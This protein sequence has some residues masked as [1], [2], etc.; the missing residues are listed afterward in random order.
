ME[1]SAKASLVAR[2]KVDQLDGYRAALVSK[3][4][5]QQCQELTTQ[6]VP[7]VNINLLGA[8]LAELRD[9]GE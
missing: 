3:I 4:S 9:F 6:A 8:A 5:S 2:S 1:L 7:L